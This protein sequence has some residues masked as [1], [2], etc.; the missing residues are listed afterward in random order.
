M[1][2]QSEIH[3]WELWKAFHVSFCE[4]NKHFSFLENMFSGLKQTVLYICHIIIENSSNVSLYLPLACRRADVKG[5]SAL[6]MATQQGEAVRAGRKHGLSWVPSLHT[7]CR[8]HFSY[9]VLYWYQ[10]NNISLFILHSAHL[11]SILKHL[12]AGATMRVI[13]DIGGSL[14]ITISACTV[15][16]YT[17]LGGLYSVAYT[18]VIQM[19]FITLSL[20]SPV[21][22]L[23]TRI[24]T[25]GKSPALLFS[26]SQTKSNFLNLTAPL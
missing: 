23:V 10:G 15:I 24:L 12:S 22:F 20:A 25:K 2:C 17:L 13:L 5:Q 1:G 4:R 6:A 11:K 18:D 7:L 21:H 3:I 16:L 14:A 26:M 9:T 19:V 8:L